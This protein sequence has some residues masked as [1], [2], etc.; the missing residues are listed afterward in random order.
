MVQVIKEINEWKEIRKGE[1]NNK[2]IGLVPTMG[3]LHEGHLSLMRRS[4]SDNEIT[5]VSSF[6]NPAQFNDKSD[7]EKY[8]VTYDADIQKLN[9]LKIDYLLYPDSEDIYHDDYKY[10]VDENELSKIL[11]GAYRKGHFEGVLSVVMKLLN[12]V[13]PQKAYFGEKD[14]QQYLLIKGMV[15][16]FFM[17]VKIIPC[18][19]IREN[20]GLAMSSRN[21]RLTEEE[22]NMATLFPS[23]LKSKHSVKKAAR[24]LKKEGFK[25]DY[26]EEIDGRR[27]GAVHL[28][29]VR[30]IDNVKR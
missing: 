18:P 5:V 30:L 8:P 21:I 10:S 4:L 16:A 7:F 6:V 1:L 14:Y 24:I 19:I 27:F 23:L 29:N 17:D 28:G 22:R 2:S 13:K 26:I 12:I 20:D 15:D 25:V 3:A 9:D 11:C